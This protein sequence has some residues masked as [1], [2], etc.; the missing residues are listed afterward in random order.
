[1]HVTFEQFNIFFATFCSTLSSQPLS[2]FLLLVQKSNMKTYNGALLLCNLLYEQESEPLYAGATITLLES[3]ILI[4][5]FMLRFGLPKTALEYLL[6][7]ISAHLPPGAHLPKTA[8]YFDKIVGTNFSDTFTYYFECKNCNKFVVKKGTQCVHCK[9]ELLK[10]CDFF[11]CFNVTKQLEELLLKPEVAANVSDHFKKSRPENN[12]M[13]DIS[14]GKQYREIV[15]G[16]H[17][18]SC[19]LN[20]DGMSP[21]KSSTFSLWAILFTL[22]ELSYDMRRKFVMIGGLWFGKGKPNFSQFFQP[23]TKQVK[24][25]ATSGISWS[26][27]TVQYK[28]LVHFLPFVSDSV[29]RSSVQGLKQH[30]AKYGCNCCLIKSEHVGKKGNKRAYLPCYPIPKL[31]TKDN[32]ERHLNAGGTVH[33]GVKSRSPLLQ[34]PFFDIINHCPIDYMHCI[35]SGVIKTLSVLWFDSENHSKPFY[36]G[37][38]ADSIEKVFAKIKVPYETPRAVRPIK[39]MAN[40]KASEWRTWLFVLPIV[41]VDVMPKVYYDHIC[42]L[43]KT[44]RSYLSTEITENDLISGEIALNEFVCDLSVLYG[45]N[46]CTYNVHLLTHLTDT[47]RNFGPLWNTSCFLFEA[48]NGQL[49][50]MFSGTRYIPSQI[51]KNLADK[52]EIV[53]KSHTAFHST[54]LKNLFSA[55]MYNE[56]RVRNSI[57]YGKVTLIGV[58]KCLS[59]SDNAL[60]VMI[61]EWCGEQPI[62]ISAFRHFI[63]DNH[64]FSAAS[65]SAVRNNDII[66]TTDG[67]IFL[68]QSILAISTKSY[69]NVCVGICIELMSTSEQNYLDLSIPGDGMLQIIELNTTKS[70][71][72]ITCAQQSQNILCIPLPNLLELD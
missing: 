18:L 14:D 36:L 23:F 57:S 15:T 68:L 66:M 50:H 45:N 16:H 25:L 48:Y 13:K 33:Y 17:D 51:C 65:R 71:K 10:D 56:R 55:I 30:N 2:N 62:S 60:F 70:L 53:K 7:I 58:R 69:K 3:I 24:L 54:T 22:N 1:M 40:W 28:S 44:V 63:I 20:S 34:I 41:L 35:C 19:T 52:S 11:V 61:R 9:S 38:V 42:K 31:R 37:N 39:E 4:A 59:M 26:Y 47:V 72:F 29:A 5:G 43:S 64:K 32:Y 27:K 8:Y 67:K 12:S 46:L 21:F 6:A 49:V